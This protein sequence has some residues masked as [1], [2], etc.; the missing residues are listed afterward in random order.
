MYPKS[1]CKNHE[2]IY[3]WG[4]LCIENRVYRKAYGS[5]HQKRSGIQTRIHQNKMESNRT[6]EI[7]TRSIRRQRKRKDSIFGT[8]VL[9]LRIK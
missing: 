6:L 3:F 4:I 9:D 7:Y 2:P 5:P 1:E 8:V